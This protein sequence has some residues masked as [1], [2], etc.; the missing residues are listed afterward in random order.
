LGYW[1]T[2]SVSE[3]SRDARPLSF[4]EVDMSVL[5][6]E[7]KRILVLRWVARIWSLPAIFFAV[8]EVLF[9]QKDSG[10]EDGWLTWA[11]VVMLFLSVVSLLI[12][13]WNERFGGWASIIS[14]LVF[15]IIYWIDAAE[16]F[17]GWLLLFAFVA[18]PA[19]LFL[20]FDYFNQK[21]FVV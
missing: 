20:V 15:F 19:I 5:Q 7:E 2:S 4:K 12:A 14:L 21:Y 13:W 9:S 10:V 6:N 3:D 8:S 18:L 17:Q 11:T 16:F 1:N